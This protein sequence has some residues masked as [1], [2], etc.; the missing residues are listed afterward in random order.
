LILFRFLN[1]PKSCQR[2]LKADDRQNTAVRSRREILGM[3]VGP[4]VA[5]TLRT[6]FFRKPVH[7]GDARRQTDHRRCS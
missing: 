4:S 6:A 2:D 7:R 5:E 3:D 1:S